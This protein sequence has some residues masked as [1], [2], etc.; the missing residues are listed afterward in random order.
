MAK[1]TVKTKEATG[2]VG[3]VAFAGVLA[4]VLGAFQT[5]AGIVALFKNEV[6]VVG[7][8]NL[9]VFD[10]TTWGWVHL[11]W[12]IFLLLTGGAILSGKK[13]GRVVGVVLASVSAL[14]NFAFIPVYPLWSIVIIALCVFVIYALTV[15]GDEIAAEEE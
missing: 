8:E 2:W 1:T 3:W 4:I 6:Y 11:L 5:I 15:H 7:P 14:V 13:W 10:Y 9:W 12:G